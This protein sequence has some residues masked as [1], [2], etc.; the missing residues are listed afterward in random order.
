[1]IGP[2][3]D[4]RQLPL[5]PTFSL[6]RLATRETW[7]AATSAKFGLFSSEQILRI[8]T[9]LVTAAKNSRATY[10]KGLAHAL[11][12]WRLATEPVDVS[13]GGVEFWR[14]KR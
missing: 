1:V 12:E 9:R 11:M 4:F 3:A 2:A 7:S 14:A 6:I 5:S 8:V 13:L 10:G